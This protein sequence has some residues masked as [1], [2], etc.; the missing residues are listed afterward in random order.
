MRLVRSL[1]DNH[2]HQKKTTERCAWDRAKLGNQNVRGKGRETNMDDT[3]SDQPIA[4]NDYGILEKLPHIVAALAPEYPKFVEQK[5]TRNSDK[6]GDRYRDQRRQ[7]M[8][9]REQH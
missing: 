4:A 7:K 6:V 5:M 9:E 1:E 2:L 8:A 3:E